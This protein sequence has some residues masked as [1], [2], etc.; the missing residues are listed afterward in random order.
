MW[1]SSFQQWLEERIADYQDVQLLQRAKHRE[2]W[3][4]M[5]AYFSGYGI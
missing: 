3:P 2:L 1:M 4:S 5:I